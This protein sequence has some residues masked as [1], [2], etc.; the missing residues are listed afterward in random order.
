MKLILG[1]A[2]KW[3]KQILEEAGYQ[4]SVMT[5]DIDEKAIRDPDPEK[6]VLKLAKAKAE[7]LLA[8]VN[9]PALLITADQIVV[10]NGEIFEKPINAQEAR[11]YLQSY[12][13]YPAQTYTAIVVTNTKTQQQVAIVDI[14]T[15]YFNQIPEETIKELISKGDIFHCAGGFQIEGFKGELNP[16]VKKVKGDIDS[17]KGLPITL[18]KKLINSVT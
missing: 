13:K 10:C 3:R 11:Y 5:A 1:S 17:V 2:S 6:L 15:V 9:E 18:L 14:A 16:Y 12:N 4:F 8:K 7:I